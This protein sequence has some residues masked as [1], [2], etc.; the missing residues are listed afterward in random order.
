MDEATL[1][2][3]TVIANNY[4]VTTRLGAGGMGTVYLADNLTLNQRV[5]VKVLRGGQ[6]GAG[7]EEAQLLASIQHPHVVTVYAHD[8]ALDCIVME[9][10]DGISLSALLEKGI[11]RVSAI[12][13]ALRVAEALAAVHKRGLVHRDIKPENVM[14]SLVTG[15]GSLVDWLKLIDFGV[16]LKVGKAPPAPLGTPEFCPPEQFQR[17]TA[18]LP[19][20]DVYALGVTLFLLITGRFPYEGDVPALMR[21][22]QTAP[23]PSLV[24]TLVGLHGDDAFDPRTRVLLEDLDELVQGMLAKRAEDRPTAADVARQLTRL[25]SSFADAGTFVG[26]AETA[27][28][29]RLEKVRPRALVVSQRVPEPPAPDVASAVTKERPALE[30]RRSKVNHVP[31]VP[32]AAPAGDTAPE[33]PRQA[34]AK[35]EA[36][37]AAEPAP[38]PTAPMP[39]ERA[40]STRRLQVGLGVVV[41]ALAT[42]L[43]VQVATSEPEPARTTQAASDAPTTTPEP[44]PTTPEPPPTTPEAIAEPR[45]DA[46]AATPELPLDGGAIAATPTPAPALD[47]PE[48]LIAP[49]PKPKPKAVPESKPRPKS[50][51][52][53]TFTDQSRAQYWSAYDALRKQSS[54]ASKDAIEDLEDE[55]SAAI[56]ARNCE[57]ALSALKKMRLKL[58]P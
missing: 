16:A 9:F 30:P 13:V 57:A 43:G 6:V 38:D 33:L 37:A 42:A 14:L 28:Y 29:Q 15:A 54:G 23:V 48:P 26:R 27:S 49:R 18:A 56:T 47:D 25:E 21:Q 1:A 19:A 35:L 40:S 34:S 52:G 46:G 8:P 17:G 41:L 53:C 4:R 11:D 20:N 55:L 32:A 58:K 2:S 24:D 51:V 3:G 31:P 10:L 39:A 22:H 50:A 12:R 36:E 44:P 45:L 5:V 7:H